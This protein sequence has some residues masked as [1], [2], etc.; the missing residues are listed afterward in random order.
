MNGTADGCAVGVV[1][2]AS[3]G[4][5]D[6]V[7]AAVR[8]EVGATDAAADPLGGG[9]AVAVA[10]TGAEDG[11]SDPQLWWCFT[12]EPLGLFGARLRDAAVVRGAGGC[13]GAGLSTVSPQPELG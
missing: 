10:P 8:L 11:A 6:V 5:A 4:C 12:V 2:M 9:V 7:V 3:P 13:V 1:A